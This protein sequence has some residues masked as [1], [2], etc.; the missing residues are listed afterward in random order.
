M[1]A[2]QYPAAAK[3]A[4]V[5]ARAAVAF[6][7][8]WLQLQATAA[9]GTTTI[10]KKVACPSEQIAVVLASPPYYSFKRCTYCATRRR[11]CQDSATMQTCRGAR[12][13]AFGERA[14]SGWER[15]AAQEGPR[16]DP[17]REGGSY[18]LVA[19]QRRVFCLRSCALMCMWGMRAWHAHNSAS[20]ELQ[21]VEMVPVVA[22]CGRVCVCGKAHVPSLG[23]R[24]RHDSTRS[25]HVHACRACR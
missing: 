13:A 25:R 12:L 3:R 10:T 11:A 2:P 9:A 14:G 17:R 4:N 15:G 20:G 24:S 18:Q 1:P 21:V 19:I 5:F 23:V 8:V 22:D 6:V 16:E 7:A